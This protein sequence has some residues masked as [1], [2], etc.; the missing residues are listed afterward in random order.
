MIFSMDRNKSTQ[1]LV[2]S[3][4]AFIS[5]SY[6]RPEEPSFM[7][8]FQTRDDFGYSPELLWDTV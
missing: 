8:L 2:S 4:L 1:S 7:S 5:V 6:P 3:M